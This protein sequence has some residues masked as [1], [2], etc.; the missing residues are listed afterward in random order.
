MNKMLL[1]NIS[2]EIERKYDCKVLSISYAQLLSLCVSV[3]I[4][5]HEDFIY[6]PFEGLAS[7]STI[8]FSERSINFTKR[9]DLFDCVQKES[10]LN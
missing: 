2:A 7:P 5:F 9:V 6:K 4:Q 3:K 1:K 10:R 8:C